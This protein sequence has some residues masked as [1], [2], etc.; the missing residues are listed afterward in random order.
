MYRNAFE[1]QRA[2][3]ASAMAWYMLIFI[4]LFTALLFLTKRFWVYDEGGS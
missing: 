1:W 3:L 4:A 2:G